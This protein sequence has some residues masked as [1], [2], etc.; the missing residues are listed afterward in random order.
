[1]IRWLAVS[2]LVCA[3]GDSFEAHEQARVRHHLE[4]ALTRLER[5][6]PRLSSS[7]ATARA[8]VMRLLREYIEA[9]RFPVNDVSPTWTPIFVDHFGNRC[10]MAALIEQSGNPELVRRIA[11]TRNLAR[12]RE[13]ADDEALVAWLDSHGMTLD[14]AARVQPSYSNEL[15]T[16]WAPT[17]AVVAT[18]STGLSFGS[19]FELAGGP[20]VRAGVRRIESTDGACDDCV[21]RTVAVML[22]YARL[23]QLGHPGTN[24]LGLVSTWDLLQQSRDHQLYVL[25][26]LV[27][28]IDESTPTQL[29]LG[30]QGGLGFSHRHEVIPWFVEG[31][32]S[33]MW[34]TRGPAL[35]LGVNL[36]VAW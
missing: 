23:V 15:S 28:T 9:G 11:S 33:A 24:Q 22:E 30:G 8:Q 6:K 18:G 20:M 19:G 34:Q 14:E 5:A 27:G 1:M 35:R 16:R 4:G 32:V 7:Q 10:A 13:L 17:A 2:M 36:G 25:A 21:Y 26:G 31:L 3:C 29:G 12:V